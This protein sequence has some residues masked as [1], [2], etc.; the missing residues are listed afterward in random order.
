[1]QAVR[2]TGAAQ[3]NIMGGFGDQ[4]Q[5]FLIDRFFSRL[6]RIEKA[7]A[8]GIRRLLGVEL[9]LRARRVVSDGQREGIQRLVILGVEYGSVAGISANDVLLA[10]YTS[11]RSGLCHS[12]CERSER[13]GP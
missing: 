5:T 9:N 6:H 3:L 1:V 12:S 2:K 7:P 8:F 10:G 4:Y 11:V 13:P